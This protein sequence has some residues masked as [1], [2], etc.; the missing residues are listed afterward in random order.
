[1]SKKTLP[2]QKRLIIW[3]AVL[4]GV[5]MLWI[6]VKYIPMYM[7]IHKAQ[8]QLRGMNDIQEVCILNNK[9]S[10]NRTNSLAFY[11]QITQKAATITH[12]YPLL[13]SRI[14]FR[15]KDGQSYYYYSIAPDSE[16][17]ANFWLFHEK[18]EKY[19][20]NHINFFSSVWLSEFLKQNHLYYQSTE[21]K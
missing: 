9:T 7:E 4:F 18:N 20:D 2:E 14:Y 5:V 10:L 13:K 21:G 12:S 15:I 1:M 8:Q 3:L 19:R 6:G 16:V 11:R 17:P